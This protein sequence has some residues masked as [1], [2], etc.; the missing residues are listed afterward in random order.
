MYLKMFIFCL[1]FQLEVAAMSNR[2]SDA[3]SNHPLSCYVAIQSFRI[4]NDHESCRNLAGKTP[5]PPFDIPF[6]F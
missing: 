3:R 2:S 1:Q 5:F 6:K 4:E